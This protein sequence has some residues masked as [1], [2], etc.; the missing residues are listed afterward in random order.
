MSPAAN[1][2]TAAPNA[3]ALSAA[4]LSSALP[5]PIAAPIAA[6]DAAAERIETP[7]GAGSMVWRAWG[8]GR[9]VVLLHGGYGSWQHWV[10]NI[11]ALAARRRVYAADMPG[12]GDS[13]DAPEPV[14]PETI[15]AILA[16]GLDAIGLAPAETDLVGFSFGALIGSHLVAQRAGHRSLTIVG[17]G[18]IGAARQAIT[19]ERTDLDLSPAELAAA[20]R[21]NLNRLMIADPARIDALAV[22]IQTDNVAR[23]RVKSRRFAAS[24][25]ILEALRRA[26]IGRLHVVWGAHDAIA[27][28]NFPERERL[29]RAIRPDLTFDL[30]PDAGHWAAYE[31]PEAFDALL[32]RLIG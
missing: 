21:R 17:A 31:Q 28:G 27:A 9:P 14:V 25:S 22:A 20:H 15:A 16:R 32:E 24:A 6:L 11:P 8:A 18:A 29:L 7:C 30:L 4:S 12:L 13:A 2:P 1:T 26:E 19:L 5:A 23:A 10:R 3:D